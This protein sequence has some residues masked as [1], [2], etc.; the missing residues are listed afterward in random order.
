[1]RITAEDVEK[2]KLA[3]EGKIET[4]EHTEESSGEKKET[5]GNIRDIIK[6]Q[7]EKNAKMSF[8]KKWIHFWY[9]HKIHFIIGVVLFGAAVYLLLHFTVFRA[10]P[11]ALCAYAANSS[12]IESVITDNKLPIDEFVERFAEYEGIDLNKNR[13]DFVDDIMIDLERAEMLDLA[14]DSNLIITGENGEVDLLFGPESLVTGYTKNGFY[15]GDIKEYLPADFYEYLLANDLLCYA[16]DKDENEFAVAV[17]VKDA[18]R[19]DETKLYGEETGVEPVAGI[20]TSYSPRIDVAV[21]F[22]EYLFDYPAC[23]EEAK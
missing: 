14:N 22:L 18:A 15:K 5:S 10:K 7:N 20:I 9:Y 11:L 12:N 13:I 23:L 19:M 1:M 4:A 21:D 6:E 17:K 2:E 16:K 3:K 8:K